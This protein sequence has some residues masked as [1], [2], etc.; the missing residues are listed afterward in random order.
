MILKVGDQVNWRG[1]WG[2]EPIEVT[3]IDHMEVTCYP[4][5]KYGDDASEVSWGTVKEN[6]VVVGL[7]NGHWAY[8]TQIAPVGEDPNDW[9]G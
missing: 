6:R 9:H 1:S 4:R 8:S 7:T 2:M 3:T 5:E